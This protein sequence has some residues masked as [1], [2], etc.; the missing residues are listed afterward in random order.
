MTRCALLACS[1]CS[2]VMAPFGRRLLLAI[3][4]LIIMTNSIIFVLYSFYEPRYK[5]AFLT[6]IFLA[7]YM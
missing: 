6:S 3:L 7:L 5:R 4:L 1:V 2:A